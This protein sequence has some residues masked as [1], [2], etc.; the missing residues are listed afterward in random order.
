MYCT[1]TETLKARVSHRCTWCAQAI[2]PGITYKRWGS[3]DDGKMLANK[4]HPECLADAQSSGDGCGFE[5]TLH[6]GERSEV[7]A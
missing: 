2:E 1:P 3:V 7:R 5:Y 6:E 4:M